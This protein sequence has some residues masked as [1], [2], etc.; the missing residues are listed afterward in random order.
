MLT[1]YE[2]VAKKLN[3]FFVNGANILNIPNYK[4]YDSLT[5][6]INDPT[7]KTMLN[8]ETIQVSSQ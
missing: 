1:N 2:E 8:E 3:N 4:N 5:E 6:K 7:L